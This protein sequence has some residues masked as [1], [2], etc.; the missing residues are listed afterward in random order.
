MSVSA[1]ARELDLIPSTALHT[2]RELTREGLVAFNADTKRYEIDAGV[3]TIASGLLRKGRFAYRIQPELN[4]IARDFGLA[5]FALRVMP[6]FTTVV[7]TADVD[8][9]L[10]IEIGLG[11][12]RPTLLGATG[13]L[14]AAYGGESRADL[15]K[16]M[17]KADW[18]EAPPSRGWWRE[19]GAV[20]KRGYATDVGYTHAGLTAVAAPVFDGQGQL[21][22][23]IVA[24][25]VTEHC[26]RVGIGR[27]GEALKAAAYHV[28]DDS[29]ELP[30]TARAGRGAN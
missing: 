28:T 2:L 27:I 20:R 6:E 18:Y 24:V 1:V 25:G 16:R 15:V 10:R 22:H 23:T 14:F 12:K 8:R 21:S 4:G 9:P 26:N 7:A 19:V 11:T 17:P 30:R 13:R 29:R 3:L 5:C